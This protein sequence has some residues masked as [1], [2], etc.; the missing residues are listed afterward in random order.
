[1]KKL[2]IAICEEEESVRSYIRRMIEK[3][4][5]DCNIA[6]YASVEEL[7]QIQSTKAEQHIDLLFT[8]QPVKGMNGIKINKPLQ[9]RN[10]MKIFAQAVRDYYGKTGEKILVRNNNRLRSVSVDDIYYIESSNRKVILYL[11]DEKITY[12]DKIGA[13][14]QMLYPDF[15]RIHKGYLVH[16]KYIKDYQRAGVCMQ[17]GDTLL[18]SK[19]KY[20]EFTEAYLRYQSR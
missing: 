1:M 5:I 12:Y 14:E 2:Y 4:E 6:E 17:N 16:M 11:K 13:L 18:I 15:F 10:F 8:N 9:E 19:Y 3:Q 20:R 7:L